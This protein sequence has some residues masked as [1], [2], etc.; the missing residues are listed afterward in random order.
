MALSLKGPEPTGLAVLKLTDLSW[1]MGIPA[2]RCLGTMP[3]VIEYGKELSALGRLNTTVRGS[4]A[5]TVMPFQALNKGDSAS[6]FW[7]VW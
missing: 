4:L 6:A 1:L 2:N 3:F 7:M 5:V